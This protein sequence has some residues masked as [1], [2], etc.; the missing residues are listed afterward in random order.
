[1]EIPFISENT[2]MKKAYSEEQYVQFAYEAAAYRA[3]KLNKSFD[4]ILGID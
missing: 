4:A 1:M 2:V 3:R